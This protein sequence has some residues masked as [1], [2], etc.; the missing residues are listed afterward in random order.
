VGFWRKVGDYLTAR[1][2][3]T[4]DSAPKPIAQ[5]L[6]EM[7]GRGASPRVGRAEALSVPAVQRGRNLI[8]SISTLPLIQIGPDR[9]D[10]RNSLF[11][12]LDPDVPNVVTLAQTLEDLLFDGISWWQIT[13]QD[14]AGYPVAVR[15]LAT[16]AV[17]LQPPGSHTP[18]PLPSGQDPRGAVVYVNGIE[19]PASTLIRFDSPNPAVLQVGGRAIRR[20]ILLDKAAGMYADDPRPLDYFTPADGADPAD[21]DEV[22]DI[23]AQWK[24][25]RKERGTAYVPQAL[26]YN[27]VDS[28]SPADLQLVELQKQAALDIANALGIDPEELG[29]S[30]TSR[31]YANA[32][33]RR[34]DRI[35]D[36]LSPFMRAITDRLTMGDVTRRG[37]RVVFDLDDYMKA[38]PTE[39]WSVYQVAEGMGAMTVDEIRAE[40]G[41]PALT[42]DTTAPA[43]P[44][45]VDADARPLRTF[46]APGLQFADIPVTGFSV[47]R[48]A[49]TIEGTALPYG[50]IG[51]KYG[52]KFRFD[53]GSLQWT[54]PG[55]V[56]LLRDH[57][58]GQAIGRATKLTDTAAGLQVRFSVARGVQGDEALSLA[59]DGV[60]DGF[61]VGVDFDVA[62]DTVP[63]PRNKGVTLVRRADLREVS[64]TAMPAFDSARVTK[65]A[66][67]RTGGDTVPED[68][69]T[70][71]TTAPAAPAVVPGP[72]LTFDAATVAQ[73]LAAVQAGASPLGTPQPAPEAR[74]FVNPV[75]PTA[76]TAVNEELPYRFDRKGNLTRGPQYD[77]S[78]DLIAGLKDGD[79][80]A[81]HRAETF[82][83]AAFDTQ[84]TDVT[85]LNPNQQRPDLYVDQKDFSYPIWD[86]IDKGTLADQT[87]FVLPKFNTA[88]G[89]VAAHTQAVEPSL[90]TFTA[91]SQTITPSALS[92]KVSITREA[93]D[94]GGNPQLSGIIWRQMTKAWY[95]ALEAAAVTLLEGLAPT[96]ITLTLASQDDVL[97]GDLEA[98]LAALQYIRGGFRFRDF[99]LQVDLYKKLIAAVDA[100]GRKLL[101]IINPTNANGQVSE[102]YGDVAVGGLRGR[103]AWATAASAATATN[104]FLFDRNDVSGWATAPQRLTFENVEVRYVHV[105]IWGY[106]ALANTDL[107]G[108]RKIS[109]GPGA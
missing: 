31:T 68:T 36:V 105:G 41:L 90:G 108:V 103:P 24:A 30:T 47:N 49:R 77:F 71:P 59:E 18:A 81:L 67:S 79:Q 92:G 10:V 89:L 95:E 85:A 22:R 43:T 51:A 107:T 94:Q 3:A 65:V 42:A 29:I 56:K 54:D 93:W 97:V 44:G 73:L 16:S 106:K 80:E 69:T 88:S 21:D 12:Q 64:L 37:H 78:R 83:R 98:A 9:Q 99:F 5:V 63:D 84:T 6:L 1:P 87:P 27:S 14:F 91:T 26:K 60:L 70:E 4:F 39:R 96:T 50:Q 53:R 52:L 38:N 23:L 61:S 11:E 45:A 76:S 40:E 48:D 109:Y 34:R 28:P 74:Q 58:S 32:V 25:A 19:V 2:T 86:A 66:A 8:C 57:D 15:H 62:V 20:A 72:A 104:S 17:S 102:F 101:P 33:D 100:N 55:R 7:A 82:M 46:D 35:N 13:A 75:R